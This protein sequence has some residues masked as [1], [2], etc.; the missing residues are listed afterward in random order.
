[1]ALT[2][3]NDW[4]KYTS[5]VMFG[6][7]PKPTG[8]FQLALGNG[9][10]LSRSSTMADFAM[11]ELTGDGYTR[12]TVTINPALFIYSN[13]N[14]RVEHGVW[15]A[16]F[17]QV[18][19]VKQWAVAFMLMGAPTQGNVSLV[20]ANIDIG[21]DTITA[22]NTWADG[23]TATIYALP[24]GTLP[25]PLV[26][27]AAYTLISVTGTNFKLSSDGG[28]SQL[29]LSSSGS[30]SFVVANTTGRIV[31]LDQRATPQLFQPNRSYGVDI[32]YTRRN[33]AQG[34]GV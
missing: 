1:M 20:P 13:A 19:A 4:L 8:G 21:T 15:D 29:N 22:P 28:V 11:A 25:A 17:A 33:V 32:T 7:A 6:S 31:Y 34:N 9:P 2:L 3:H 10:A 27:G 18:T 16:N 24:G 5:D 12:A 23:Q 26:S 14:N 30:G